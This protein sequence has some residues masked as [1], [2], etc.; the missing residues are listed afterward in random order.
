MFKSYPLTGV[1]FDHYG[2]YFKEVRSVEY[3]LR[4]G[5]DLTS[6]NAHN[7]FLQMFSTGGLFLGLSYLL[8]VISTLLVGLKLVKN[9]E[10]KRRQGAIG[11]RIT[12]LAF[13]RERRMPSSN[14]WS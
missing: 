3:P 6:T 2:Y 8:L 9:S 12:K 11:P 5:F 4:Y 13:G 1:G 10:W 14:G 7:T